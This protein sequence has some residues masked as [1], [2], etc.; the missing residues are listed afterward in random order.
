MFPSIW[1]DAFFDLPCDESIRRIADCGWKTLE[2]AEIH[3]RQMADLEDPD[4]EAERIGQLASDLGVSLRQMHGYTFGI[5]GPEDEYRAGVEKALRSIEWGAA[6]GVQLYVLHPGSAPSDESP[7]DEEFVRGRNAEVTTALSD[8]AK[9]VGM[10]IALENM[11]DGWTD[12]GRRFG[13]TVQ[14]LLW[15]VN[16]TDPENVGVCWDT[17]HAHLQGLD[18]GKAI[19]ALGKHLIATHIDDNDTSRDQHL[20]PYEG[21]IDWED[22]LTALRDTGYEGPFNLEIGGGVHRIPVP[23]RALKVR[24]AFDLTTAMLGLTAE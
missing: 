7:A 9:K 2:L 20:V 22:M 17:G 12:S 11:V 16:Q 13:A 15:L 14:E 10:K 4:K 21:T 23:I 19:R 6:M 8:A 1:T 5:C 18:Q 24:Y 3:W